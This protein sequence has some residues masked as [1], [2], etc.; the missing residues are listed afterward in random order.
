VKGIKN[1]DR[2]S[3]ESHRF[4]GGIVQFDEKKWHIVLELDG[5]KFYGKRM[6]DTSESA[7]R[8]YR[9]DVRPKLMKVIEKMEAD[10]HEI[11]NLIQKDFVLQ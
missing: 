6:H 7:L 4:R 10:G 5:Q 3:Q 8:E 1:L 9:E 2:G 11:I